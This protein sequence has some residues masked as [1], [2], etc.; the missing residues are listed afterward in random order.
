MMED[1]ICAQR[2]KV[3]DRQNL[4]L[5]QVIKDNTSLHR[6]VSVS[7]VRKVSSLRRHRSHQSQVSLFFC[8]L[9]LFIYKSLF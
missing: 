6:S 2:M 5:S 4:T 7:R 3:S 1:R 9:L 8:V